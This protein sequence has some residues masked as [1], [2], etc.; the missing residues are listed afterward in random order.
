M[1][2]SVTKPVSFFFSKMGI[3]LMPLWIMSL[4]ALLSVVSGSSFGAGRVRVFTLV[5]AGS[6]FDLFIHR[7]AM[8][9]AYLPFSFS[10]AI[11]GGISFLKSSRHLESGSFSLT[12]ANP[13]E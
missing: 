5:V 9:P 1:F 8:T 7:L 4:A 10:T 12:V 11:T 3:C 2:S 6:R 13:F